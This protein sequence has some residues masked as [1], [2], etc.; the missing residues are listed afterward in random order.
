M[1]YSQAGADIETAT[2]TV[3]NSGAFGRE[4]DRFFFLTHFFLNPALESRIVMKRFPLLSSIVFDVETAIELAKLERPSLA[5]T[6]FVTRQNW[7]D[8]TANLLRLWRLAHEP[9]GSAIPRVLL[10]FQI[11]ELASDPSNRELRE[12]YHNPK[13]PPDEY[14]EARLLR[15]LASHQRNTL[16]SELQ[17]YCDWL[18]IERKFPHPGTWSTLKIR[19][20]IGHL[21]KLAASLIDQRIS[22]LPRG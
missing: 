7:D 20:A 11:V 5:H 10:L 14:A 1:S 2:V 4:C 9:G 16:S 12:S 3:R 21:R 6:A 15:N 8:L 22:R 13:E 17:N 18:G 19:K